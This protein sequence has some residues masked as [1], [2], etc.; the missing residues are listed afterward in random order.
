MLLVFEPPPTPPHRPRCINDSDSISIS[1]IQ[2]RCVTT[3]G[4]R[5]VKLPVSRGGGGG[6]IAVRCKQRQG[7]L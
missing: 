3:V 2:I 4:H 5:L 6:E 1:A 7:I